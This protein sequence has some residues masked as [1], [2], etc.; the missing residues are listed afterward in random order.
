[1]DPFGRSI[2]CSL[3]N[4]YSVL[5]AP[6]IR[7]YADPIVSQ[8]ASVLSYPI[9]L[10]LG[11]WEGDPDHMVKLWLIDSYMEAFNIGIEIVR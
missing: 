7:V 10:K 3:G 5:I 6:P 8:L 1:M 9:T 11:V 4:A 2:I